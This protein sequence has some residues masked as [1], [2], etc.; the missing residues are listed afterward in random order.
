M[1][2]DVC[3]SGAVHACETEARHSWETLF[4]DFITD[5]FLLTVTVRAAAVW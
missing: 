1:Y 4:V 5:H 2:E 3:D